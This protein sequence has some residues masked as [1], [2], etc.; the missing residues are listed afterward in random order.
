MTGQDDMMEERT[1]GIEDEQEE[2][3]P[4]YAAVL[5]QSERDKAQLGQQLLR[6]KADFDN[7]RR[8]TQVQ[9]EDITRDANKNLLEDLLPILDNFERA[10]ASERAG[11]EQDSFFQG[12]EMVYQ[13][14][15]TNLAN[16]GLQPIVAK[17]EPFDPCLHE[18]VAMQGGQGDGNLLVLD[19]VQTGYL[20]HD[21]VLRHTRALVGPN[22]EEDECQK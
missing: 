7:F 1:E 2:M 16:H 18:A 15:I 9:M 11:Q 5:E 21:K 3:I 4:D 12:I 13:G 10:L 20:L 19:V 17:G 22:K 8:R 14:L 6:L